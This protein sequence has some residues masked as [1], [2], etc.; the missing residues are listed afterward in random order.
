VLGIIICSGNIRDYGYY[1]KYLDE[2]E[3]II[4]ADGGAM[5]V[6]SFRIKPHVLLGDFDSISKEDFDYFKGMGIK[7]EKFPV[8]KDQTDTEIA[9]DYAIQKG[10]KSIIILG[11]IGYRLDHSLSNIFLLKKMLDRGVRGKIVDEYNEIVLINDRIKLQKE[12]DF[13]ITLLP[14]TEKTEGVTTRGLSYPLD[15]ATLEQGS[16]WGVSNE[17]ADEFAEVFIKSGLLLVIKSRD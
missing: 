17:F 5:H 2:A 14:L 12:E 13:K 15:N 4:C 7:I 10:C 16:T 3:L 8:K 1:K 9:V 11:G 6:K